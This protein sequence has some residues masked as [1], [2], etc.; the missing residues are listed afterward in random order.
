MIISALV[1]STLKCRVSFLS[2]SLS[3]KE[4]VKLQLIDEP[5]IPFSDFRV[6]L[7]Q[8]LTSLFEQR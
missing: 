2:I 7:I 6:Q 5:K 1:F 8:I 4:A 3:K